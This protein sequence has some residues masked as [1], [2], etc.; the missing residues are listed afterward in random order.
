[1]EVDITIHKFLAIDH[2]DVGQLQ[3]NGIDNNDGQE[4]RSD[5]CDGAQW[6]LWRHLTCSWAIE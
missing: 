4:Q 3:V 6:Q 2:C 1:M 5:A